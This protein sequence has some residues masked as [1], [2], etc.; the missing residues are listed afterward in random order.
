MPVAC[1]MSCAP[2]AVAALVAPPPRLTLHQVPRRRSIRLISPASRSH[3]DHK[4]KHTCVCRMRVPLCFT[5]FIS[6]ISCFCSARHRSARALCIKSLSWDPGPEGDGRGCVVRPAP[7]LLPL[8]HE[9]TC[10][11]KLAIHTL[12]WLDRSHQACRQYQS[13]QVGVET[14]CGA[15]PDRPHSPC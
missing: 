2:N 11:L 15:T 10:L 14:I 7:G 12:R 6:F 3:G 1:F 8:V 4:M 9:A 13:R 5:S